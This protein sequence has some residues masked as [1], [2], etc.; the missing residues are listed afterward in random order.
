MFHYSSIRNFTSLENMWPFMGLMI[1][2]G[3]YEWWDQGCLGCGNG[4]FVN[5]M[6]MIE[7]FQW[8]FKAHSDYQKRVRLFSSWT[9]VGKSL[10][11]YILFTS[12]KKKTN[13]DTRERQKS[14]SVTLQTAVSTCFQEISCL[15][16][17]LPFL[18]F[19]CAV[20][21]FISAF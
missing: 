17:I 15:A 4:S 12:L 18:S 16:F 1:A 7:P 6:E 19:Y 14:S 11:S 21:L 8:P 9:S 13:T 5:E 10:K 20:T 2:L 3:R